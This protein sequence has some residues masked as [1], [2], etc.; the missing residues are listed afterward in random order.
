MIVDASVARYH[1]VQNIDRR[2]LL[3]TRIADA[4]EKDD[5]FLQ[6]AD[7]ASP[8]DEILNILDRL[9]ERPLLITDLAHEDTL[10]GI[11]TASDIL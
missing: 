9:G 8:D 4:A 6:P 11:L 1:G 10:V 3:A 2:V 5:K 7:I